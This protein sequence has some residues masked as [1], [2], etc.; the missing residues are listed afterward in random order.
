M[1]FIYAVIGLMI[2]Y[3]GYQLFWIGKTIELKPESKNQDKNQKSA[4]NEKV[5]F[6]FI[7]PKGIIIKKVIISAFF[8][9]LGSF[10]FFHDFYTRSDDSLVIFIVILI[11]AIILI[12]YSRSR[13]VK[14]FDDRI[15]IGFMKLPWHLVVE[16]TEVDCTSFAARPA[17]RLRA[18]KIGGSFFINNF[19][20]FPPEEN[21]KEITKYIKRKISK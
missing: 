17:I 6:E 14:I 21:I 10:L 11:F 1:I 5:K 20:I 15:L 8:L 12:I 13:S 4:P 7:E 18:K 19:N 3:F 9:I 2:I 16:A